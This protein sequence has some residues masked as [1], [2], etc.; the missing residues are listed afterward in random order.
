[1]IKQETILNILYIH[2]SSSLSLALIPL[3]EM[4][5]IK[6][7]ICEAQH[8]EPSITQNI[9]INI[10]IFYVQCRVPYALGKKWS[11]ILSLF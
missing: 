6:L 11:S 10:F 9:M 4:L 3:I 1:M 7:K 5:R 2:A 8:P